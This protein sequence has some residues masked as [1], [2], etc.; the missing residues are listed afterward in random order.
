MKKITIAFSF[1]ALF[2]A[3]NESSSKPEPVVSVPEVPAAPPKPVVPPEHESAAANMERSD[4]AACHK[5]DAVMQGPSYTDIANKYAVKPDVEKLA[6]RIISGGAG[7]WGE[8]KMTPHPALGK[9][10][11]VAMVKY[12]L[13]FKK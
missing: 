11:A 8:A 1:A 10:D 9:E 5:A 13:S 7:I 12:I 4:C 6:D 3:C 2:L